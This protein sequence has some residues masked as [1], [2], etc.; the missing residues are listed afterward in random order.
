MIDNI[1]EFNKNG[2]IDTCSLLNLSSSETLDNAAKK[3][4]CNFIISDFIEYELLYKERNILDILRTQRAEELDLI[5]N[6]KIRNGEIQKY[7]IQLNDLLNPLFKNHNKAKSRG[8]ITAIVLAEKF[9]IGV[10][11]DDK[12]AQNVA[13]ASMGNEKVDSIC[14]LISYM[15][16]H[17]KLSDSDKEKMINEQAYFFRNQEGKF[18]EAYKRGL[19]ERLINL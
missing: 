12:K 11:T 3:E 5:I 19:E 2:V 7:D 13:K 16:Y 8:E 9:N 6:R 15:Y 4:N 1:K 18:Q 14:T 10:I 17:N